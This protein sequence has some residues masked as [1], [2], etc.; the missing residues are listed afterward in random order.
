MDDPEWYQILPR[1]EQGHIDQGAHWSIGLI[2]AFIF[3]ALLI[4]IPFAGAGIV[5]ILVLI[6]ELIIQRPI[7]RPGDTIYDIRTYL[8]A[9]IL[10]DLVAAVYIP[11]WWTF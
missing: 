4:P 7:E 5:A 8:T 6:Y 9:A 3:K 11:I 1:E 10:G 2:L